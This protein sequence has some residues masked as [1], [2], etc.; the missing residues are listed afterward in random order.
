[1]RND[2]PLLTLLALAAVC[3]VSHVTVAESQAVEQSEFSAEDTAARKPV[4]LPEDV[5]SILKKDKTVQ[6]VLL[7]QNIQ[8][9]N[10][11]GSW[12]SASAI[13]L[14]RPNATDLVV[15]A[16]PPLAGANV[17][18]F[19]VFCAS[20]DTY[21]LV[22]TAPAHDL[23]VKHTRWK[24]HREIELVSATAVQISTV[25]CRFDGKQY[26][27]YLSKLKPVR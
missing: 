17:T 15:V 23:V 27:E 12:F 9:E 13:H 22:L 19:W 16:E 7:D 24:A 25:L 3:A 20:G 8:P 2:L 10:L 4:A 11:P 5:L 6:S 21:D 1:M 26:T 14:S 18:L